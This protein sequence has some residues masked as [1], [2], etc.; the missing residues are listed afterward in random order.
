MTSP[1]VT[2]RPAQD[3]SA[4]TFE[5]K[6]NG[7][8]VGHLSYSLPDS[9]TMTI[10]YV[11]VSPALQGKGMGERLVGAAVAWARETR[12]QVV[13]HCSYA[14]A[15]MRRKKAYQDVLKAST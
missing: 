4:G 2:H 3:A 8:S 1:S 6:S 14:R 13:P 9:G 7:K 5:L 11:E 12:R 10:D 15:V